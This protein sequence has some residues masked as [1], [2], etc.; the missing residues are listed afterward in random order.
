[1]KLIIFCGRELE[2][3]L[4][5]AYFKRAQ[6][7]LMIDNNTSHAII[8][9]DRNSNIVHYRAALSDALKVR[10]YMFVCFILKS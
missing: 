5:E 2:E 9:T 7:K 1:M 4:A 10:F 6:A 8:N 3:Q